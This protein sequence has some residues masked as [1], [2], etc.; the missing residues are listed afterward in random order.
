MTSHGPP[1]SA[2]DPDQL[3]ELTQLAN[4]VMWTEKGHFASAG[5]L[6][7]T[8]LTVGILATVAGA[9]AA[10]S[11]VSDH[12]TLAGVLALIGAMLSGL[13]TFLRPEESAQQH[14]NAGR[15]LGALRVELRQA[16]TLDSKRLSSESMRELIRDLAV[17]KATADQSAPHVSDFSIWWA[18]RRIRRGD[19]RNKSRSG[20]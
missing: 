2:A 5:A 16:I 8:R 18:G 10:A 17:K 19:S 12:A 7:G 20:S 4:D 11:I 13:L 1:D 9:T 14:L 15:Q 3:A 6:R